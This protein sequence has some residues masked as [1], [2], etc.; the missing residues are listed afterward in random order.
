[1]TLVG[2][3]LE[4]VLG[5]TPEVRELVFKFMMGSGYLGL[6]TMHS[7]DV[8][9]SDTKPGNILLSVNG[10]VIGT[11]P[12]IC[13]YSLVFLSGIDAER[14]FPY[15][16]DFSCSQN[17]KGHTL[18]EWVAGTEFWSAPGAIRPAPRQTSSLRLHTPSCILEH[19]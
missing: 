18:T 11:T 8:I 5:S 17:H 3:N 12:R 6:S 10:L 4:L 1:M 2:G 14:L 15:V 13:P 16:A 19:S 9:H 7:A